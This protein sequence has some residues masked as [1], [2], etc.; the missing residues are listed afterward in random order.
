MKVRMSCPSGSLEGCKS[1][2][3]RI[4]CCQAPTILFNLRQ[5]KAISDIFPP[6][7]MCKNIELAKPTFCKHDEILCKLKKTFKNFLFM[8]LV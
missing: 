3:S 4:R 6:K 1:S 7:V 2:Y 5:K 8:K